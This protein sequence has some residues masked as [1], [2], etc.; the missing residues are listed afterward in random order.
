MNNCNHLHILHIPFT[1]SSKVD[2]VAKERYDKLV[3]ELDSEGITEYSII[4]GFYDPKNI[5]KAIHKGHQ[6]IV[7]LAKEQGMEYCIIAEDD[8]K[9]TA[10]GAW[11]YFISQIPES[12]DLFSGV[13]YSASMEG[14][15]VMNGASGIMSLYVV[16]KR[17]YDFFLS[18][19]T[20]N[21]VDREAGL[22]AYKHEYYVCDPQVVIQRGGY[23]FNLRQSMTYEVYMEGKSFYGQDGKKYIDG[24]WI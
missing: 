23:S 18:M 20:N 14:N 13:V 19:N 21:H 22:T 6:L 16:S 3:K 4:E 2:A 8:L 9:F 10:P 24:E 11:K 5:K 12:F 17:H 1:G 7:R 15:R